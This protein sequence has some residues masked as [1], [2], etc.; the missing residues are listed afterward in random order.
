A[1]PALVDPPVLPPEAR[2]TLVVDPDG[3]PEVVVGGRRLR[4]V[5]LGPG[6]QVD[7]GGDGPHVRSP[8]RFR[9]TVT[10]SIGRTPRLNLR[11]LNCFVARVG[12]R[13]ST[14]VD[15]DADVELAM[16]AADRRALDGVRCTLGRPGGHG[17]LYDLGAVTV[18]VPGTAG[19]V[20]LDLGP[21]RELALVHRVTPAPRK[22][23]RG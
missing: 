23:R 5:P 21:G 4:L 3:D 11:G 17:W 18:A 19:V 1:M 10:P 20:L 9:L 7:L 14:A 12:G 22:G 16:M 15:V 2:P 8:A 13:H 6:E